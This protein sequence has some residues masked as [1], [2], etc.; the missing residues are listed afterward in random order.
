[1]DAAGGTGAITGGGS[2]GGGFG[3]D[4]ASPSVFKVGDKFHAV[5]LPRAEPTA[6]EIALGMS[7]D[8]L[9]GS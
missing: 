1:M 3:I 5:V 6:T 7:N 8:G 9:T 4:V 2:G